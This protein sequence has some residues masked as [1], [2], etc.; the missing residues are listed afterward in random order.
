MEEEIV[1]ADYGGLAVLVGWRNG[2]GSE[3]NCGRWMMNLDGRRAA[4]VEWK[5]GGACG[6]R[7]WNCRSEVEEEERL[8]YIKA[9]QGYFLKSIN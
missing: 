7:R 5:N 3:W 2:D 1:I 6:I 9:D 8:Q 4:L